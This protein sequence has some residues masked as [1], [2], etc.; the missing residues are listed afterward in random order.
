MDN[1]F[2]TH[3]SF[4]MARVN[5]VHGNPGAVLFDSDLRHSRYVILSISTAERKRDLNHDYIHARKELIEVS[6]S[7]AQWGALVS[8]FGTEGVPCTISRQNGH[9]V[10]APEF[11]PRL[12]ES[13]AEVRSAA[14]DATQ[15]IAEAFAEFQKAFESGE[16]KKVLREKLGT[17]SARINNAPKNMEYAAESLTKH[18]ENVVTKARA[19]IEAMVAAAAAAQQGIEAPAVPELT[20]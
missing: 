19:D 9:L 14:D 10:E 13:M 6:M 3:P 15:E 1:D 4:A 8:S 2:E 12:A 18:A 7:Q 11:A 5:T 17:L 20:A 16:G